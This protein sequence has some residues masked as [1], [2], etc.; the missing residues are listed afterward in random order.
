MGA[1]TVVAGDVS[2]PWTVLGARFPLPP[3]QLQERV[4]DS[5]ARSFQGGLG[6]VSAR[7]RNRYLHTPSPSI[8]CSCLSRFRQF[9]GRLKCSLKCAEVVWAQEKGIGTHV[10]A[11]NWGS[12]PTR[13]QGHIRFRWPKGELCSSQTRDPRCPSGSC[14]GHSPRAGEAPRVQGQPVSDEAWVVLG[15]GKRQA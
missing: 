4:P 8:R 12:G 11:Q 10:L 1:R 3:P 9:F 5:S 13:R 15:S 2:S 7:L 6:D 14:T